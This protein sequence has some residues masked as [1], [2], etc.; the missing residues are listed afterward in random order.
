MIDRSCPTP[1]PD[2]WSD[3]EIH[4]HMQD[5]IDEAMELIRTKHQVGRA[6]A[7]IILVQAS[8]DGRTCVRDAAERILAEGGSPTTP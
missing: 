1:E 6:S 7:Y 5:T 3:D 2:A 8:V 4:A